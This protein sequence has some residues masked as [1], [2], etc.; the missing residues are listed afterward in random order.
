MSWITP[1]TVAYEDHAIRLLKFRDTNKKQTSLFVPPQAGHKSWIADYDDSK[2]LVQCAMNNTEGGVY[3]IDWKSATRERSHESE[4]DLQNQL[5]EAI[6][7]TKSKNTHVIGLCQGGWVA[8][9]TATR[10]P[11]PIQ[12]LT[13]AGTPIDTSYDSILKQAQQTPFLFY[14]H[15]VIL[16]GGVVKGD[17]MLAG[18][19]LPNFFEH[20]KKERDPANKRFY[21][22]YNETQDLAGIW[23]LWAIKNIFIENNLPEMLD[24]QCPVNVVV[25]K[26]DDITPPAQTLAV[27]KN[28]KHKIKVYE[29]T[30][31][32]I[33]VF[34]GTDALANAWPALFKDIAS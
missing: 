34:T 10:N 7:Q 31:G 13:L 19:K 20:M 14:K 3:A 18:W 11:E 22:W 17:L 16:G 26:K 27:Q 15:M 6:R 9:L 2:S 23:Y 21:E 33:G 12:L 32:H 30:G 4:I 24:I 28:C 8:A 29:S 5:C 1:Y 25:G